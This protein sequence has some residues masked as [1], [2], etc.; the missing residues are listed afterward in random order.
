MRRTLFMELCASA[1]LWTALFSTNAAW[2]AAPV[3]PTWPQ[4][5]Q[6]A[7][8]FTY[9]RLGDARR[10]MLGPHAPSTRDIA[11]NQSCAELYVQRLQLMQTQYNY[12]PPYTQDPRNRAAVF[13]GTMF[14]PAFFY[15]AFTGVQAYSAATRAPQVVADLDGLS[16]ASAQQQCYVR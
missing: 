13:L 7:E 11:P 14:P 1:G 2:A 5:Q 10:L 8:Q 3:W 16:Y 12:T 4:V 9:D 6:G 15:L